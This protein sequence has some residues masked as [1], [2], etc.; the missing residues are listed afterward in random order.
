VVGFARAHRAGRPRPARPH[1]GAP[2]A[3]RLTGDRPVRPV[4]PGFIL[5]GVEREIA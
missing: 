2:A 5:G 1:P 3:A 4:R